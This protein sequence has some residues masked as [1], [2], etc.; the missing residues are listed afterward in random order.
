MIDF[1][2]ALSKKITPKW[3]RDHL[4]KFQENNELGII[5]ITLD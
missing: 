2:T 3:A 1:L 4:I 5:N